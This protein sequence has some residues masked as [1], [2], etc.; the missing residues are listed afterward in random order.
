MGVDGPGRGA[1][2]DLVRAYLKE[3]GRVALLNAEQEVELAKRI[4]AGLLLGVE[5]PR[6]QSQRRPSNLPG[7]ARRCG[8][9][10]RRA[11]LTGDIGREQTEHVAPK[12]RQYVARHEQ[13]LQP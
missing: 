1:S 11:S 4:E 6:P 3:I 5:G 12:P 8:G 9:R 2:T 13:A 10:S 7:R